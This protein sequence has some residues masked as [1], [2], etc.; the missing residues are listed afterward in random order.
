MATIPKVR[1]PWGE[2][3]PHLGQMTVE[4][5]DQLPLEEGWAYELHEGRLISMPGPGND[6]AMLQTLVT[7]VVDSYLHQNN[8]G[9][10][11]GTGCYNLPIPG[12]TEELLCPDLSYVLPARLATMSKRG[13]YLMGAPDLVIEI[14]SPGDSHPELAAKAAIYLQAGVR[15][16][17][18]L[19]SAAHTID[20][21]QGA[22]PDAPRTLNQDDT[23][24]G[25]D[26]I[27]GFTCVV[28]DLFAV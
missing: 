15:L 19:W 4:Q 2:Y 6:H 24:G 16:M 13:A 21:W 20:V 9:I 8:L 14:A 11:M 22:T 1:A 23:L 18:M 5:F 27:P 12:N 28:R 7:R 17:W 3:V 25:Q 26:V 10:L